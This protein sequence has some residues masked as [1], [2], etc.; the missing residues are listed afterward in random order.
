MHFLRDL[1]GLNFLTQG[2]QSEAQR[3]QVE[4]LMMLW[5]IYTNSHI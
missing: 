5:F 3:A 1:S 2:S 4:L